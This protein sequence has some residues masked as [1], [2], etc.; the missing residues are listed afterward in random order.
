[1]RVSPTSRHCPPQESPPA[2]EAGAAA[3]SFEP[4]KWCGRADG[5]GET[6]WPWPTPFWDAVARRFRADATAGNGHDTPFVPFAGAA[7]RVLAFDVQ[8]QQW[9]TPTPAC[10]R[11]AADR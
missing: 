3:G 8:P 7:G 9:R 10:G 11:T 6:R 1:M 2:R 4:Q 5:D